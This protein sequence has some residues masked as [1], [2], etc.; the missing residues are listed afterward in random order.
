MTMVEI[1]WDRRK[2][3]GL[4]KRSFALWDVI[5]NAPSGLLVGRPILAQRVHLCVREPRSLQDFLV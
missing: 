5:Q 3:E 1:I 4:L 2:A